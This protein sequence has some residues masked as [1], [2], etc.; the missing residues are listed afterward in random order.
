M[1]PTAESTYERARR[2]A[3]FQMWT[4]DLQCRRLASSEPED[5]NFRLRKWADIAFL[6]VALTRLQRT[7][8]LASKVPQIR[9]IL[10]IALRQFDSTL[11]SLKTFRDV[12]EHVD[13]YAVDRGKQS[14]IS[15]KEL[16]V[17][18]LGDD[19]MTLSWLGHELSADAALNASRKLF[20]ALKGASSTLPQR[21][22]KTRSL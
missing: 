16:E 3:N 12:A 2:L 20:D 7:V 10:S 21:R 22:S 11:P 5:I 17:S 18:S 4:I 6:I 15:R 9:N 19:G 14:S 13:D 1:K 8:R